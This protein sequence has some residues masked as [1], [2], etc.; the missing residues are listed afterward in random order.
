[1]FGLAGAAYGEKAI[2][3][4]ERVRVLHGALCYRQS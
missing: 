4:L 1:M 2:L 3:Y